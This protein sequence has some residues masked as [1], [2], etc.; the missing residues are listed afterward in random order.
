MLHAN[1]FSFFFNCRLAPANNIKVAV[2]SDSIFRGLQDQLQATNCFFSW[3]VDFLPGAT[4]NKLYDHIRYNYT[5]DSDTGLVLLHIGTNNLN[6]GVWHQDKLLYRHLYLITRERFPAAHITFSFIL[7][8]WDSEDLHTKSLYYNLKLHQLS[9][10]FGRCNIF[11]GTGPFLQHSFHYQR[12]GLHLTSAGKSVIADSISSFV[13][14]LFFPAT[15]V[16]VPH[17]RWQIPPICPPKKKRHQ[18]SVQSGQWKETDLDL[19][20]YCRR[21]KYGNRRRQQTPQPLPPKPR[22]KKTPWQSVL[23]PSAPKLCA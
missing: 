21:E 12:D 5:T 9:T 8:R 18:E 17:P 14:N 10:S 15:R 3:T 22:K 20:V 2:F 16:I 11:D 1:L 4:L 19:V 6:K 7:P 13:N 23:A